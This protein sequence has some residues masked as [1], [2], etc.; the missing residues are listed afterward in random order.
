MITPTRADGEPVEQ[1]AWMGRNPE[2]EESVDA[3]AES[4]HEDKALRIDAKN[5]EG[6]QVEDSRA[7]V[8]RKGD[9]V[10]VDSRRR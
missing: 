2:P 6:S 10:W 9:A 5:F 8:D 1:L 4:L 7:Y 3:M